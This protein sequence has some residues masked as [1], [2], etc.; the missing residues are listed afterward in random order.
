MEMRGNLINETPP[1]YPDMGDLCYQK[2]YCY[3]EGD[4]QS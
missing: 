1:Y 2:Q 3:L 4:S